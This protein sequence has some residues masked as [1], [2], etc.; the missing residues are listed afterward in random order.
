MRFP[1]KAIVTTDELLG[2][3]ESRQHHSRQGHHLTELDDLVVSFCI[4]S[5]NTYKAVFLKARV[6]PVRAPLVFLSE[7]DLQVRLDQDLVFARAPIVNQI[8]HRVD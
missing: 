4:T 3:E 6:V 7:A 5:L 1:F 2:T 8:Y